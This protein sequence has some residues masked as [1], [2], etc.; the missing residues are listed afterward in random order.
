M[1]IITEGTDQ[2]AQ[3]SYAKLFEQILLEMGLTTVL[4]KVRILIRADDYPG[5]DDVSSL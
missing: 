3:D 1:E 2:F 4:Q 5:M